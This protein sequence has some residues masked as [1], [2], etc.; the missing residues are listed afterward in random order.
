MFTLKG[1]ELLD[2]YRGCTQRMRFRCICGQI[3]QISL[4]KFQRGD[5]CG[6]CS[7]N[8]KVFTLEEVAKVFSERGCELLETV[9]HNNCTLMNYRCKCGAI[10]KVTFGAFKSQNQNCYECGLKKIKEKRSNNREWIKKISGANN[11]Q[12]ITDRQKARENELFRKKMYKALSSSLKAGKITKARR[13]HE[14]LGYTPKELQDYISSHPN[15]QKVCK[16]SWH[17]DHIFPINAFIENGV[18]DPKIINC[19]E[20]LRPLSGRQNSRKRSKYDKVAFAAWLKA[21]MG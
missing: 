5:K 19:L 16:G 9:Y 1:Y 7:P 13:T 8:R 14:I 15:Y 6:K 2:Q 21:H 11:Y 12:W 20:N 17:L 18:T 10:A 3:G 4:N